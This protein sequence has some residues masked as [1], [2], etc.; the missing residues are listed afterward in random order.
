MKPR[1]HWYAI[2]LMLLSTPLGYTQAL[3]TQQDCDIP[4]FRIGVWGQILTD[5]DAR[6]S[7]YFELRSD[8]EKGLPPRRV[9][10]DPAE[11]RRWTRALARRIRAARARAKQGD[12]FTPTISAVFRKAL[13][14]EMNVP[15]C[16]AIME[17]NPGEVPVGINGCYPEGKP[18]ETKLLSQQRRIAERPAEAVNEP[19]GYLGLLAFWGKSL[20]AGWLLT[21]CYSPQ[22]AP[23]FVVALVHLD[24][25]AAGGGAGWESLLA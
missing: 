15:T 3:K 20:D 21:L 5:F 25:T 23:T 10:K 1:I 19:D 16:A 13:L 8:L 9:T 17:D 22:K 7:T 12:I 24:G 18:D 6:V 2:A 11:I 4:V 14:L